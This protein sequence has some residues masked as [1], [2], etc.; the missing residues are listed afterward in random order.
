MLV[1]AL[2]SM[3]DFNNKLQGYLE[4]IIKKDQETKSYTS[5]LDAEY[6]QDF[7]EK[8]TALSLD[9][10]G[11]YQHLRDVL[12]NLQMPIDRIEIDL[13][14][15]RDDLGDA[16]RIQILQWISPIP[17]EQ[18]HNQAK[19]DLM[20]GTGLW[21][22]NDER[23]LGWRASSTSSIMWLRGIAGSGKS[24][25]ISTFIEQQL[26]EFRER[27]NPNPIYF[28]C[29]RNPAEPERS[30]PDAILR[31]L[32]R[33]LSVRSSHEA[34]LEPV[35]KM[36]KEREDSAFAAGPWTLEESTALIIE[37][38]QYRQLTTIIVDALDECE[39]VL[40][41][42]LL[43][44][45]K[46]ILQ[47]WNGLVKILVSSRDVGD[48]VY[49]LEGCLNLEIQA[50]K[51]QVDIDL[52]VNQGVDDLIKS[53]QLL[54]GKISDDLR[55]E[56]KQVLREKA[57]GMSRWVS[58]QLD[59]LRGLK[60]EP[61]VRNRL[62]QLPK[63]L[64]HLY[65]ETYSQSVESRAEEEQTLTKNALRMLL[66]L[67]TPLRTGD[68]MLALCSCEDAGLSAED[69]VDLCSSFIILILPGEILVLF[70]AGAAGL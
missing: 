64:L 56:I 41:L 22:L 65:N 20:A 26:T 33:Q 59:F 47:A 42:K 10:Q 70:S 18:H 52:F 46:K 66:C 63:K 19:R 39:E 5:L 27:K 60:F 35:R 3:T 58:L 40:R 7:G 51:N 25:L 21:F 38:S 50:K 67:Q 32:V 62:R 6:R 49:Q 36:Y 43:E 45:F 17:Y 31:S 55:Q 15:V 24:K 2:K 14:G 4:S 53:R 8:L 16:K 57:G 37:L 23:L 13:R 9:E 28:Y 11:K 61:A 12:S 29:T 68:F 48:I 44:S 34:I 30:K 1:R 69:L 54:S